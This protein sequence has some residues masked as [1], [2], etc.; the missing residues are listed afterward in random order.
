MA[1]RVIFGAATLLS[2]LCLPALAAGTQVHT[3][4]VSGPRSGSNVIPNT[5]I[6]KKFFEGRSAT[7]NSPKNQAKLI[8]PLVGV[9]APGVEGA[10]GTQSGTQSGR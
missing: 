8:A 1:Y 10:P 9:G 3:G 6:Q 4:V 5:A 7:S 2:C